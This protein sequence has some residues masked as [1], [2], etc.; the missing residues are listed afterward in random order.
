MDPTDISPLQ[1]RLML[2]FVNLKDWRDTT[3]PEQ[4]GLCFVFQSAVFHVALSRLVPR[5]LDSFHPMV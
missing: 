2:D 1:V 3:K 5:D 4:Q